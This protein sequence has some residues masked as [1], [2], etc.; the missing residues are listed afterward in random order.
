MSRPRDPAPPADGD[1][2]RAG[3]PVRAAGIL[4]AGCA[5]L[6]TFSVGLYATHYFAPELLGA[7]ALFF[8]AFVLATTVPTQL[9]FMPAELRGLAAAGRARLRL[10]EQ[11]L[12]LGLLPALLPAVACELVALAGT[13]DVTRGEVLPL[14]VTSILAATASPLQDHLRRLLHMAGVSWRAA[15]V[16]VTQLVVALLA[17]AVLHL[18]GAAPGWIPFG[19]LL[20]ANLASGSFALAMT[21]E[22][23]RH[24]V[25]VRLDLRDLLRTGRWLLSGGLTPQGAVFVSGLLITQLAGAAAM[26]F[27]EAARQVSAPLQVLA[28][29]LS[30]TAAPQLMDAGRARDARAGSRVTRHYALVMLALG[31]PY[32]ALAGA[33][34]PLNPLGA[35]IPAAYEVG[36]LA[37]LS[38]VGALAFALTAPP[39]YELLGAGWERRLMVLESSASGC[40]AVVS[41]SAVAAG[42]YAGPLGVLAQSL[43]RWLL[44]QPA[45]AHMYARRRPPR[46]G[47]PVSLGSRAGRPPAAG[48]R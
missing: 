3:A 45:R 43:A 15:I 48:P 36:G 18:A 41:L 28:T 23:R 37:A 7:Y 46:G 47:G 22:R 30:A 39:R 13:R 25:V 34:W 21:R 16:S 14:T 35:I 32:L 10:L 19:A 42:P 40:Q 4:D 26:G 31:L 8:T 2:P 38:V 24:A 44:L 17:L 20:V 1:G 9:L 12:V 33:D 27:V 11:S 5:S 6:A 29:G